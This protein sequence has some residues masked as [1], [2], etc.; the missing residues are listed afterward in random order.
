LKTRRREAAVIRRANVRQE[1]HLIF[2]VSRLTLA[3]LIT[4]P[5]PQA[6]R[7]RYHEVRHHIAAA[8]VDLR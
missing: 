3:R 1:T 7:V 6:V 4:Q 2:S 5:A 8:T